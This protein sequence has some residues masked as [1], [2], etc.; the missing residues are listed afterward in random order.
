MPE[1]KCKEG[2]EVSIFSGRC[3]LKCVDGKSRSAKTG[4][5]MPN[6]SS[7][8]SSYHS[9]SSNS[10]SP[11]LDTMGKKIEQALVI[12]KSPNRKQ[13]VSPDFVLGKAKETSPSLHPKRMLVRIKSLEEQ[14][15]KNKMIEDNDIKL[16]KSLQS[17]YMSLRKEFVTKEGKLSECHDRHDML[18]R[19]LAKCHEDLKAKNKRL[20]V[21][22]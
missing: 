12:Y 16:M 7:I 18:T 13:R 11:I 4:K 10:N 20:G 17:D 8:K 21:K 2:K 15:K 19:S 9:A 6:A 1:K 3:V 14:L 22:N 5:C